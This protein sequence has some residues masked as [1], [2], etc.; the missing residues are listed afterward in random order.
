MYLPLY[1]VEKN[2]S[3]GFCGFTLIELLVV[4]AIIAILA[5]MLLPALSKARAKARQAVCV[6]NLKQ[7]GLAAL[8]YAHDY[9][10]IMP[11]RMYNDTNP[12]YQWVYQIQQYIRLQHPQNP[13]VIR[14]FCC[15][16]LDGLPSTATKRKEPG[17]PVWNYAINQAFNGGYTGVSGTYR[18]GSCVKL[19]RVRLPVKMAFLGDGANYVNWWGG[20][21]AGDGSQGSFYWYLHS[22]GSNILF[23]DG[24]VEWKK[25][26]EYTN[27]RNFYELMFGAPYPW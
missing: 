12:P 22:G 25:R 3:A 4:V 6:S 24:H 26:N 18:Y 7:I 14:Y 9:N 1:G 19:E 2:F 11:G 21:G 20:L 27:A 23:V 17:N 13:K 16:E 10:G 5:A 8:I 15:G